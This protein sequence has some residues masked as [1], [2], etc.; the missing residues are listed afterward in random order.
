MKKRKIFISITLVLALFMITLGSSS[1]A[2]AAAPKRIPDI[3]TRIHVGSTLV[4]LEVG[5]NNGKDAYAIVS[6]DDY[7]DATMKL[8]VYYNNKQEQV[9]IRGG[10]DQRTYGDIGYHCSGSISMVECYFTISSIDG[11]IEN[12]PLIVEEPQS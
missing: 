7:V 2:Y 10:F 4:D 8:V 5:Y 6:A 9:T 11:S 12:Y 1:T 3:S